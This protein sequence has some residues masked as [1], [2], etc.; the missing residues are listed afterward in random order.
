MEKFASVNDFKERASK[1]MDENTSGYYNSGANNNQA[2]NENEAVFRQIKLNPRILKDMTSL[3]MST[4][5]MGKK[6]SIPFGI[7][8]SA[9][10]KLAH[11]EGEKNTI[12]TAQTMNTVFTLSSLTTTS[13]AEVAA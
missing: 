5:V 8:P 4:T 2:L 9:M 7:A 1:I 13:L 11:P 6:V 12:R 3:D 10:H